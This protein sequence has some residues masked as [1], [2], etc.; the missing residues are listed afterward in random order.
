MKTEFNIRFEPKERAED[1]IRNVFQKYGLSFY[2]NFE[3]K[4]LA[5][6]AGNET[7]MNSLM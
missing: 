6:A 5:I 3:E 4:G 7:S 2:T 1:K